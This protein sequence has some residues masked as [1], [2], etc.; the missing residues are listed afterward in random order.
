MGRRSFE[1]VS[2]AAGNAFAYATELERLQAT[3]DDIRQAFDTAAGRLDRRRE[4]SEVRLGDAPGIARRYFSYVDW[5]GAPDAA[6]A[7]ATSRP[8]WHATR[9]AAPAHGDRLEVPSGIA[10]LSRPS[11]GELLEWLQ[12]VLRQATAVYSQI[13][14]LQHQ[15]EL[16]RSALDMIA[17]GIIALDADMK[18]HYAN[19][20]AEEILACPQ[21]PLGRRQDRMVAALQCEQRGLRRMVDR[22]LRPVAVEQDPTARTSIILRGEGSRA[23]SAQ[24]MPARPGDALGGRQSQIMIALR[25]LQAN[26]SRAT[27]LRHLFDLTDSEARVA[28]ALADGMSLAEAAQAHG[29]RISTARTHLSRIFHKTATRQQ[30]QLVSLLRSAV[31]P[32]R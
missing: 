27:G 12:P 9:E 7:A 25:P 3:V 20:E 5:T 23:I 19:E 1:A 8:G 32:L 11:D 29:V 26:P 6:P 16:A 10:T 18:I 21:T 14:R 4:V 24:I 22:S 28:C 13:D 17:L 15:L 30:S 31:L 2:S